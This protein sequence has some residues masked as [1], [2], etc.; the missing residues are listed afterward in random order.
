MLLHENYIIKIYIF[1]F[2][3]SFFFFRFKEFNYILKLLF[4]Y[5]INK[6]FKNKQPSYLFLSSIFYLTKPASAIMM[7]VLVVDSR[8][9]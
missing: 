6:Y 1:F 4:I 9:I 3:L 8:T 5:K 2:V 7:M